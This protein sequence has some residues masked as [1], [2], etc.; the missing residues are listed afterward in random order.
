MFISCGTGR[1][2]GSARIWSGVVTASTNSRS[3]P[4]SAKRSA[5]STAASKP[6]VAQASVRAMIIRS[7]S[8]RASTAALILPTASS[9]GITSLPLK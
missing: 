2:P 7:G 6:K 1:H 3:A 8:R 4:A 9:V 5:R